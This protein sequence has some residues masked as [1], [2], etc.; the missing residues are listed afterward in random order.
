VGLVKAQLRGV[1]TLAVGDGANDVG[2]IQTAHV[3]VGIAGFEGTQAV[4][5]ADF[6]I[7]RFSFLRR[8]L[9]V[10]GRN[11]YRRTSKLIIILIYKNVLMSAAAERDARGRVG[12]DARARGRS[13]QP[14]RV[15]LRDG[16]LR[17]D[18]C[19]GPPPLDL[20]CAPTDAP[21]VQS[22]FRGARSVRPGAAS[23]E[24]VSTPTDAPPQSST[25]STPTS[26]CSRPSGA[27]T[28]TCRTGT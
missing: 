5:A 11:N 15:E 27:G 16:L 17:A 28:R 8:L 2:M 18:L 3:G 14:V 10:H 24:H 19:G 22:S 7:G 20:S 25:S 13:P 9:L 26:R 6:A 21:L 23:R 4:N 1:R 12:T